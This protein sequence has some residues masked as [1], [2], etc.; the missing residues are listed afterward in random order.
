M[1]LTILTPQ[2]KVETNLQI[3]ELFAPG[4]KGMLDI[5]EGHAALVSGLETG[6]LRWRSG[7]NWSSA[8][9][10]RGFL[11]VKDNQIIVLADVLERTDEID[12]TRAKK[13]LETAQRK[14]AEGG[15]DD[16]NFKKFELKLKRAM[17]R[18]NAAAN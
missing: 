16:M 9:I 14:L 2:R 18:I 4:D 5:L 3:E 8:V 13:A 11:E 7:K 10:S 15:L 17:S 12:I 1:E 6:F